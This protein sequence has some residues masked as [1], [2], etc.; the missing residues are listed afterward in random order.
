[1]RSVHA[2]MGLFDQ[3]ESGIQIQQPLERA[4]HWAVPVVDAAQVA[5]AKS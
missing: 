1:M 5:T 2:G 3:A 4:W